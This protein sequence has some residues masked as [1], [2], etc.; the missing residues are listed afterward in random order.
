MIRLPRFSAEASLYCDS[1]SYHQVATGVPDGTGHHV[2]GQST[3]IVPGNWVAGN[4]TFANFVCFQQWNCQTPDILSA[5]GCSVQITPNQTTTGTCASSGDP[6]SC[7]ACIAGPPATPC[8][9]TVSCP[10]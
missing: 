8:Q 6:T 1:A 5:Q 4:F 7:G 3:S 10:D 9:A 2:F